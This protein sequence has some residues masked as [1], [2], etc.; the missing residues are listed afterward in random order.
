MVNTD[1]LAR[2]LAKK[3]TEGEALL[4]KTCTLA[5]SENRAMTEEEVAAIKKIADEGLAIQTKLERA[6]GT[7]G[8]S[9]DLARLIGSSSL[10]V[11]NPQ[12][13]IR[14]SMGQQ[15]V[16][17]SEY[18][19]FKKG[20][21]RS[22]SAWRSPSVELFDS[23]SYRSLPGMHAATLTED[24]ASGGALVVPDYQPGILPKMT[25][26]LVVADLIAPGTTDSNAVSYMRSC[27]R[28]HGGLGRAAA[29]S[30]SPSS[31]G[32]G[33]VR[34]SRTGSRSR[35]N[36]RACPDRAHRRA[37]DPRRADCR[38]GSTFNGD[39]RVEHPQYYER[40]GL[41][42]GIVR[43]QPSQRGRDLPQIMRSRKLVHHAGRDRDESLTDDD[44]SHEGEGRVLRHRR[45]IHPVQTATLGL[46]GSPVAVD[47]GA[48]SFC[49]LP[50]GHWW[51]GKHGLFVKNP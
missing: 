21:H 3:K 22:S 33:R 36:A 42:V 18:E 32:G 8:L 44:G 9:A 38:G 24:P 28:T 41:A 23:G 48:L 34:R 27:G 15:F 40:V 35:R 43:A 39:G 49:A 31:G 47:H 20:L 6:K 45:A 46:L 26:R 19:F 17:S 29:E 4:A 5:E 37:S 50:K 30:G 14:L 2:D 13:T 16:S 10:Q 12:Q 11:A 51:V 25:K 1:Q 7:A